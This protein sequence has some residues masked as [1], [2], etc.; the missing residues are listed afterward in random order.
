MIRIMLLALGILAGAHATVEAQVFWNTERRQAVVA[1]R[2]FEDQ[3]ASGRPEVGTGFFV[4]GSGFFVTAAHVVQRARRVQFSLEGTGGP[5]IDFSP[6]GTQ[7]LGHDLA[8]LKAPERPTPYPLLPLGC[9]ETVARETT[10]R[11]AGFPFGRDF[12]SRQATVSSNFGAAGGLQVDGNAAGGFSGGPALDAGG[13]VVGVISAGLAG[14]PGF[15]QIV[16]MSRVRSGLQNFGIFVPREG[17]CVS[18]PPTASGA[19]VLGV[20][21]GMTE[22]EAIGSSQRP[23]RRRQIP[24]GYAL[25]HEPP[26]RCI[27]YR[28]CEGIFNINFDGPIQTARVSGISFSYQVTDIYNY[29]RHQNELN[30][31][32]GS[33][34]EIIRD[35]FL[36]VA[37]AQNW[38]PVREEGHFY[39]QQ[40][41]SFYWA[42]WQTIPENRDKFQ[43][44]LSTHRDPHPELRSLEILTCAWELTIGAATRPAP[45]SPARLP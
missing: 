5:W 11:F 41:N 28:P 26:N 27:G 18:P 29:S 16:P 10:L 20:R 15:L 44:R 9:P 19:D 34:P 38:Q 12:D 6:I 32:I 24:Q 25:Y 33:Q 39:G 4:S 3:N 23:L 35:R 13:R 2:A 45:R 37:E 21:L 40:R 7:A 31:C 8:L 36:R 14:N 30:W 1:V 22:G 42:I 17:E 43:L